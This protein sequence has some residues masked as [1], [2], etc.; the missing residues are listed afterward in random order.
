[1]HRI[2]ESSPLWNATPESL[3]EGGAEFQITPTGLDET[4]SQ[5]LHAN[6]RYGHTELEWGARHADVLSEL[7]DGRMRL[8]MNRFHELLPTKATP[9][10]PF[11]REKP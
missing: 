2:T 3:R 7:P 10:F 6:G 9:D 1:M 4:S 8:D 5:A 11:P